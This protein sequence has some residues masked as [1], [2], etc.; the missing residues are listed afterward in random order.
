MRQVVA[1]LDLEV[2]KDTNSVVGL[3]CIVLA[4]SLVRA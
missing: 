4:L 3:H 1:W 2:S